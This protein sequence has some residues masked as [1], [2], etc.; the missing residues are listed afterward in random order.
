MGLRMAQY[1]LTVTGWILA[2][3]AVSTPVRPAAV[4]R[5][6]SLDLVVTFLLTHSILATW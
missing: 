4:M 3:L 5:A 2:R 6:P 1:R